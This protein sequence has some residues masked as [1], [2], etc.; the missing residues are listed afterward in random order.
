MI[1]GGNPSEMRQGLLLGFLQVLQQGAG[2]GDGSGF[3]LAAK[4]FQVMCAELF[5]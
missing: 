3:V 1:F 5:Q 4:G 2:G